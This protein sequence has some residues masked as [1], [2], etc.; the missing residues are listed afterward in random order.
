V[1]GDTSAA[2]IA[3]NGPERK[4][5]VPAAIF[6]KGFESFSEMEKRAVELC[7]GRV[8]DLGAGAGR[9]S[10]ALQERGLSVC[11]VEVVPECAE[12][13]RRRGVREV[14][15]ADV[16]DFGGGTFDTLL[17]AM[18][19][20]T[21]VRELSRLRP[22]LAHLRG[23]VREGG[24][25]LVDS[26]DLRHAASL[27][28]P[29]ASDAQTQAGGYFGELPIQL[30]YGGLKGRRFTELYVDPETL[31]RHAAPAGWDCE[32][33]LRQ[34]NGRYLARLTPSAPKVC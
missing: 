3:Y 2:F 31:A 10:L 11:A 34:E 32:V 7:S 19:G 9:H 26:T 24:Q 28:A 17:G 5:T 6:F 14:C 30:E 23:L 33:L 25:Y 15:C 16:L 20:L 8:L 4:V 18:N 27:G 22:F 21:M 13:M 29:S 1:L 12:V